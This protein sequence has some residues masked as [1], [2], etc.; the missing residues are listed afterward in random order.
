MGGAGLGGLGQATG[1][2][3]AEPGA[4]KK[5]NCEC[6]LAKERVST[7]ADVENLESFQ[8]KYKFKQ[9]KKLWMWNCK[10]RLAGWQWIDE[11]VVMMQEEIKTLFRLSA[12]WRQWFW[13][14]SVKYNWLIWNIWN[15]RHSQWGIILMIQDKVNS[16]DSAFILLII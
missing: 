1:T 5:N 3:S 10:D 7:L 13:C 16:A 11:L 14:W 15:Y 2:G 6:G 4:W 9:L 12:P 8:V